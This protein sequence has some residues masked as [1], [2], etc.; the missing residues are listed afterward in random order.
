M[1]QSIDVDLHGL[2]WVKVDVVHNRILTLRAIKPL[3][4]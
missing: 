2:T 1:G 4:R 3:C